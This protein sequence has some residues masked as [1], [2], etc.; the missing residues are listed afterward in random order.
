MN[1]LHVAF[2]EPSR[3]DGV[4]TVL[5]NLI[6]EQINLGNKVNLINLNSSASVSLPYEI[7]YKTDSQIKQV[8]LEKQPEIVI[9]HMIYMYKAIKLSWLLTGLNIKYLIQ[10]H[11]GFA[12]LAQKRKFLKKFIANILLVNR[13]VRKSSGIVYLNNREQITSVYS[14]PSIVVPNGIAN[15]LSF[16]KGRSQGINFLF[17]SRID[18]DQKGLDILLPA[19]KIFVTSRP[20]CSHQLS[21][22]GDFTS[23][24]DKKRFESLTQGVPNIQFLGRVDGEKKDQVFRSSDILVLV[25]RYEGMPMSILEALSYKIPCIVSEHTNVADIIEQNHCGWISDVYVEGLVDVLNKVEAEY[26]NNYEYLWSNS[27]KTAE[28]YSW[29]NIAK[30][31]IQQYQMIYNTK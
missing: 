19:W 3:S 12:P 9:F 10:P 23:L 27:F 13:F 18:V 22:C 29:E 24:D 4:M 17:L 31:S 26:S 6:A 14:K 7:I 25:S 5:K 30:L 16:E 8:I 1:I 20:Y 15:P 2:Y 28:A 21:I 11:G